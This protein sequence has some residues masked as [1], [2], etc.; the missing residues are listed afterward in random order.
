MKKRILSV[1]LCLVMVLGMFPVTTAHA[2]DFEPQECWLCGHVHYSD[3]DFCDN[4][5]ACAGDTLYCDGSC[6]DTFHCWNC[7]ACLVDGS[8]TDFC[9]DCHHCQDCMESKHC[10]ECGLCDNDDGDNLC[11]DC[12]R[13]GGCVPICTY[14]GYCEDCWADA[15]DTMHCSICGD[16]YEVVGFPEHDGTQ[17]CPYCCVTCDQCGDWETCTAD[18]PEMEYCDICG[19]CMDCCEDN[20]NASG[21]CMEYCVEDAEYEDHFCEECGSCWCDNER[22]ET[23]GLC[24]YC[25]AEERLVWGCD[26]DRDSGVCAED[27]DFEEHLATVHPESEPGPHSATA[28]TP[29]SFDEENHW[30]DCRFCDDAAHITS[31]APHTYDS[32]GKCTTCGF[33]QGRPVYITSQPKTAYGKV[34]NRF[35][36]EGDEGYWADN[37]VTFRVSAY[38]D[39]LHYQWYY[40][41]YSIE[42]PGDA[43]DVVDADGYF[44]GAQTRRLTVWLDDESCESTLAFFCQV[45]NDNHQSAE[46]QSAKLI[47]SHRYLTCRPNTSVSTGTWIYLA[48]DT[49]SYG[50]DGYKILDTTGHS[51]YCC[52][53]LHEASNPCPAKNRQPL[54]HRYTEVE[55]VRA[56]YSAVEA[57]DGIFYDFYKYTCGDCGYVTYTKKHVHDF[58]PVTDPEQMNALLEAGEYVRGT[59]PL[60]CAV[61]GCGEM[62]RERHEWSFRIVAWPTATTPGALHKECYICEYWEDGV[63]EAYKPDHSVETWRWDSAEIC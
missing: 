44:S 48:D 59:H 26:C 16:C 34:T 24:L 35:A 33:V 39:N 13:C 18:D 46:S 41:D 6:W 63:W 10:T 14:C 56:N 38:G 51:M 52:G 20:R 8:V 23:C 57:T 30:K 60:V 4:C 12:H 45:W 1:L 3:D 49:A 32:N 54:P 47:V 9:E 19:L 11:P 7:A 5:G 55:V 2:D 25:C 62:R 58:Q 28:K 36:A 17:H 27:T 31:L 61:D 42:G 22:C 43:Q 21:T 53:W 37:Y 29:W 50:Y 40:Y 15:D